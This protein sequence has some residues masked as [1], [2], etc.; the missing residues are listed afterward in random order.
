MPPLLEHVNDLE[1]LPKTGS[2]KGQAEKMQGLCPQV[3]NQEASAR[4]ERWRIMT[5][6]L[7]KP[8]VEFRV[9]EVCV[10]L[11]HNPIHDPDAKHASTHKLTIE[12]RHSSHFDRHA[13]TSVLEARDIP[14]AI[15][16]LKKAH[17]YLET[18][19][20]HAPGAGDFKPATLHAPARLP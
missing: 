9:G 17:D 12:R 6:M 11:W 2:R 18:R 7:E 20:R 13:D 8:E 16:A 19:R 15:L 3:H 14:K 10:A 5:N 4:R 1:G